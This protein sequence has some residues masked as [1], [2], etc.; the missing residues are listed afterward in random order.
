MKKRSTVHRYA[1]RAVHRLKG[2]LYTGDGKVASEPE[3][4]TWA[5]AGSIAWRY[6]GLVA[7]H[8]GLRYSHKST[9]KGGTAHSRPLQ[10]ICLQGAFYFTKRSIKHEQRIGKDL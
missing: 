10:I 7:F 5:D 4:R 6:V 8:A 2:S 9:I 1:E 3:E